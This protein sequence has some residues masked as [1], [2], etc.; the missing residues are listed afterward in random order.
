MNQS[1]AAKELKKV[2]PCYSYPKYISVS[3]PTTE[4]I[5]SSSVVAVET[6]EFFNSGRG[7]TNGPVAPAMGSTQFGQDCES[8]KLPESECTGH[9]GH[10]AMLPYPVKSPLQIESIRHWFMAVCRH[11]HEP[12]IS[13]NE[14]AIR[15]ADDKF[16]RAHRTSSRPK[17]CSRCKEPLYKISPGKDKNRMD[18]TT[19]APLSLATNVPLKSVPDYLRIQSDGLRPLMNFE[20]EEFFNKITKKTVKKLGR[21]VHP[22]TFIWRGIPIPANSLRPEQSNSRRSGKNALNAMIVSLVEVV[23]R[24]PE[25]ISVK[26]MYTGLVSYSDIYS[27]DNVHGILTHGNPARANSRTVTITAS[28]GYGGDGVVPSYVIINGKKI[29]LV[30]GNNAGWRCAFTG[31]FVIVGD[32]RARS[33]EVIIPDTVAMKTTVPETVNRNNITRLREAFVNGADNYP[34]CKNVVRDG[35]MYDVRYM[36]AS[37]TLAVG[38]VVKRHLINKDTILF[39]RPPSLLDTN[40]SAHTIIVVDNQIIETPMGCLTV[41]NVVGMSVSDCQMYN[42]DFDG[43]AMI[44]SFP[45]S[46]QGVADMT[47]L[48]GVPYKLMSRK[49][50]SIG[51]GAFQDSLHGPILMTLAT[52]PS[53]DGK[54]TAPLKITKHVAM[55]MFGNVHPLTG[56]RLFFK[57]IEDVRSVISKVLPD[58]NFKGATPTLFNEAYQGSIAEY[59]PGRLPYNKESLS[60][61][62]RNGE[63]ISGVL[64]KKVIGQGGTGIYMQALLNEPNTPQNVIRCISNLYRMCEGW[65]MTRGATCGIRDLVRNPVTTGLIHAIGGR[66]VIEA[67]EIYNQAINGDL[68]PPIGVSVEEHFTAEIWRVM[69]MGSD[70][71]RAV[72]SDLDLGVNSLGTMVIS[73]AKGKEGNWVSICDAVGMQTYQG[74]PMTYTFDGTR[75]SPFYQGGDRCAE[76]MGYVPNSYTDGIAPRNYLA[77]CCEGRDGIV[78]NAM[79]APQAGDLARR[80]NVSMQGC[81]PDNLGTIVDNGNIIQSLAGDTGFDSSRLN[82]AKVP[83]IESTT[84][85]F[86]S[87]MTPRHKDKALE[88]ATVKEARETIR[89]AILTQER[90]RAEKYIA[91][92]KIILPINLDSII[93]ETVCKSTGSKTLD[94]QKAFKLVDDF[95]NVLPY[96]FMNESCLKRK[97]YIPPRFVSACKIIVSYIRLGLS[98]REMARTKMCDD[99]VN[100]VLTEVWKLLSKARIPAGQGVGLY[101][102]EYISEAITQYALDSKHRVGVASEAVNPII[103]VGELLDARSGYITADKKKG[104]ESPSMII[105]LTEEHRNSYDTAAHIAAVVESRLF[106]QFVVGVIIFYEPYGSTPTV[107]PTRSTNA[108]VKAAALKEEKILMAS[109]IKYQ[110][111]MNSTNTIA[112][113][114][115]GAS[116]S[117]VPIDGDTICGWC[118][119]FTINK[120]MLRQKSITI[121][122]IIRL[123]T[124]K[125]GEQLWFLATPDSSD[126]VWV[127]A[128]VRRTTKLQAHP[129]LFKQSTLMTMM[130]QVLHETLSGVPRILSSRVVKMPCTVVGPD[131]GMVLEQQ[132]CIRTQGSNLQ[133]VLMLKAVDVTRTVTN[134]SKET[135][136]CC[137]L[138]AAQN[139]IFAEFMNTLDMT[140]GYNVSMMAAL[141]TSTGRVT[142]INPIGIANRTPNE[143]MRRALAQAP[144]QISKNAA[145]DGVTE[146]SG[147]LAPLVLGM[148]PKVGSHYNNMVVDAERV[149]AQ[150]GTVGAEFDDLF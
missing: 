150:I 111:R 149:K 147:A 83:H 64:D 130:N 42:A 10:I 37:F 131:G 105:C 8:C 98:T 138:V 84:K 141:M 92:A 90:V 16:A 20:I 133:E 125:F 120:A 140:N 73:G 142:A 103:R 63:L 50:P 1:H 100:V 117:S 23:K 2:T 79:K 40:H 112:A 11:C 24:L 6:K 96:M 68:T 77:A 146:L 78:S 122:E 35:Q 144:H 75:Y 109:A 85:E 65:M 132:W 119:R 124:S 91:S 101:V 143:F 30:R 41:Y 26:D 115:K 59:A 121:T 97:A 82:N 55:S 48:M 95:C 49:K 19:N 25:Y 88:W 61:V 57:S 148:V 113:R 47:L 27:L 94:E 38:D 139:T 15:D 36:P 81:I 128:Y 56:D 76:A 67:G 18:L 87:V 137:G 102:A 89:K 114:T 17:S 107:T 136:Q 7:V 44:L 13:D 72:F 14:L 126:V 123:L 33:G 134:C 110:T 108:V 21:S 39:N 34:G 80:M 71:M 5:V 45:Q 54:T 66:K 51:P 52:E 118:M 4:D 106:S 22:K 46:Q 43:D 93:Y 135:Q 28:S 3:V 32:P 104:M 12:V 145:M 127:R 116:R 70:E 60:V 99:D 29:G 62:I 86:E 58:V 9:A 31:R 129:E 53:K 74:G 69:G